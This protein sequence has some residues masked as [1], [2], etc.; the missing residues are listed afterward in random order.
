MDLN[1]VFRIR[2]RM[3]CIDLLCWIRIFIEN[4]IRIQ[5]QGN[6]PK[7]TSKPSFQPFKMAFV[8]T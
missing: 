7:L 3:I 6:L 8:P 1:P 4:A 2:I 5:E